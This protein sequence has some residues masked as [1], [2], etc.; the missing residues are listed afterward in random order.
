MCRKYQ[1]GCG[2]VRQG[3]ED[4]QKMV[5]YRAS[6]HCGCV[7]LEPTGKLWEDMQS[8]GLSVIQLEDEG[9][10]PPV[11]GGGLLLGNINSLALPPAVHSGGTAF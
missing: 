11:T 3:R 6:S 4:S 7:E 10:A 5:R 1:W 8:R 2:E 9:T